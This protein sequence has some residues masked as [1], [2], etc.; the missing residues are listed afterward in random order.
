VRG[1]RRAPARTGW[2]IS[3]DSEAIKQVAGARELWFL[4][5][6]KLYELGRLS[7]GMA[8]RLVGLERVAFLHKLGRIGVPAINLREGGRGPGDP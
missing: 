5:A 8:A 4:A 6:A 1:I 7:S 2:S 3:A